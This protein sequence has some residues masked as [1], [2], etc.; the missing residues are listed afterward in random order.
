MVLAYHGLMKNADTNM[1]SDMLAEAKNAQWSALTFL[2]AGNVRVL[3]PAKVNLM[4]A[5]GKQRTDGL[6]EVTTVMH[7]LAL[8]DTLY[9]NCI[10]CKDANFECLANF[11]GAEVSSPAHDAL[12]ASALDS[13]CRTGCSVGHGIGRDAGSGAESGV[14]CGPSD[15]LMVNITIADKTA[16]L[17]RALTTQLQV[18]IEQ[19]LVFKA[20]DA[21]AHV[22]NYQKPCHIKVHIEKH[23]PTQA[24]LG[25]GSSDAA[26]ALIALAHFW[27]VSDD[28]LLSVASKLGADVAFFLQGGCALYGGIGEVFQR[29]LSPSSKSVVLVKPNVGVPTKEAYAAFD[30]QPIAVPEEVLEQV[31]H[32]SCAEQVPLFNNLT[33]AALEVAP[34]INDIQNWL[35]G[36]GLNPLLT[37]SGS[38]VFAV[39]DTFAQASKIAAAAGAQGWWSRATTLSKISAIILDT[40]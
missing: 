27:N 30:A 32:A 6:H 2:G 33:A 4:L 18:P 11:K 17:G 9:F 26:A 35:T 16:G 38:T 25:G 21:L 29:A 36:C 31:A 13:V 37:G 1:M 12:P 28:V 15:N 19:N 23:I 39:T 3:A 40:K 20:I 5:V 34:I 14:M 10:P 22:V 7:A 8:H 24:G